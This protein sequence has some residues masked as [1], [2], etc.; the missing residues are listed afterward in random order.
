[1][2]FLPQAN[3]GQPPS[4]TG[5]DA[6][7]HSAQATFTGALSSRGRR[8]DRSPFRLDVPQKGA[9]QTENRRPAVTVLGRCHRRLGPVEQRECVCAS[10][11]RT[12]S[13]RDAPTARVGRVPPFM[14]AA[15]Q[16]MTMAASGITLFMICPSFRSLGKWRC[17]EGDAFPF[18][19]DSKVQIRV[20]PG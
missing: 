16:P 15:P 11:S 4:P 2:A 18:G 9:R 10:A 14:A 6:S 8:S 1:M 7:C 13:G 12:A 19:C 5:R 3:S 20:A 17:S